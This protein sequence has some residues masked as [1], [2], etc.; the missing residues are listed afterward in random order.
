MWELEALASTMAWAWDTD[1]IDPDD[2]DGKLWIPVMAQT[3][4]KEWL[5]NTGHSHLWALRHK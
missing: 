1:H 2:D 4:K 3:L 5:K